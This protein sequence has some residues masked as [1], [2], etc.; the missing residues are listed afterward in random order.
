MGYIDI[1]RGP[2]TIFATSVSNVLC[3]KRSIK[4]RERSLLFLS[5]ASLRRGRT[6]SRDNTTVLHPGLKPQHQLSLFLVRYAAL[7]SCLL[8][9]VSE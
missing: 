6:V 8:D 7:L 3:D 1:I 9:Y 4:S 5:I 2:A